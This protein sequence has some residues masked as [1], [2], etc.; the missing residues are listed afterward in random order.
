MNDSVSP[1][2]FMLRK[3]SYRVH[4]A[5]ASSFRRL[6]FR[7]EPPANCGAVGRGGLNRPA[8]GACP[9]PRLQESE[10]RRMKK[11]DTTAAVEKECAALLEQFSAAVAQ[12]KLHTARAISMKLAVARGLSPALVFPPTPKPRPAPH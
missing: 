5:R 12:G 9:P 2:P 7:H 3:T 4:A 11:K 10:A 8:P 6:F 1:H